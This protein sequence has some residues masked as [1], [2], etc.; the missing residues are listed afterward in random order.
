MDA[1]N[2]IAKKTAHQEQFFIQ[3]IINYFSTPAG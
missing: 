3:E 2:R 1:I